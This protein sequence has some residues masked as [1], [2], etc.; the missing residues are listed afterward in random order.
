MI[1]IDH[2]NLDAYYR[3]IYADSNDLPRSIG[4]PVKIPNQG[5]F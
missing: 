2:H 1:A 5:L 4:D 3:V